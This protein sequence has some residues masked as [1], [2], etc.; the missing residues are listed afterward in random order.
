VLRLESLAA[1][2]RTS[3]AGFAEIDVLRGACDC[4]QERGGF[5]RARGSEQFEARAER[6]RKAKGVKLQ[7]IR[8]KDEKE[9]VPMGAVQELENRGEGRSPNAR[10]K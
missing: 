8:S 2:E 6:C 4:D 1:P 9:G 7:Y 3:H 10:R 5:E